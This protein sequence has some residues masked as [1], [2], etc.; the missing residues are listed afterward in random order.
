MPNFIKQ[1]PR[2]TYL[3][4]GL[5][6]AALATTLT[7]IFVGGQADIYKEQLKRSESKY[8]SL[9]AKYEETRT[10]LTESNKRLRE[11][12]E[13]IIKPDGTKITRTKKDVVEETRTEIRVELVTKYEKIL[14]T[15]LEEEMTKS[16]ANKKLSVALGIDTEFHYYGALN[17][18]INSI[19][20]VGTNINQTGTVGV[21]IGI[22]F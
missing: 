19:I 8:E 14:K 13:E 7:S 6:I 16:G 5:V 2:L 11:T 21:H 10:K 20:T 18:N 12:F 15:R 9:V 1:H 4:V 17:Y 3:G 22:K